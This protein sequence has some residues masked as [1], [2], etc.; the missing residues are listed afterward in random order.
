MDLKGKKVA[1]LGA[2]SS[3]LAAAALALSHGATVSA[4]DSGDTLR[5]SPAV[6]RFAELGVVLTCGDD[7]LFSCL[8]TVFYIYVCVCMC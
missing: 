8:G 1:V 5:L 3:G 4:F 2:G 7:A 6:E